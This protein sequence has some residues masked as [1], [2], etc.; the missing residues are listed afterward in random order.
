MSSLRSTAGPKSC[1]SWRTTI[2]GRAPA[3]CASGCLRRVCRSPMPCS[4][5]GTYLGVPKPPFTPGYELVG[6]VEEVGPGCSTLKVGDR[7]VSLTVWGAYAE[8]GV[9]A[10]GERG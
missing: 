9:C 10:G 6:V 5:L 3:K 8:R 4:A 2:P 1:R 7:V